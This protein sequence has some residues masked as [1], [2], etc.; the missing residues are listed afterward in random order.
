[1]AEEE[2]DGQEAAEWALRGMAE[3]PEEP[4][5]AGLQLHLG[6]QAVCS[7]A[8]GPTSSQ[9]SRAYVLPLVSLTTI[10]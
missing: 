1:M 6:A 7:L 3:Y 4:V 2:A 9:G 10:V 8:H 5:F